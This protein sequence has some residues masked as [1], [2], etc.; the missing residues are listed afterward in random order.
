MFGHLTVATH[1]ITEDAWSGHI[2]DEDLTNAYNTDSDLP[3]AAFSILD[4]G[5][6]QRSEKGRTELAAGLAYWQSNLRGY[7]PEI[8]ELRQGPHAS[9]PRSPERP[10]MLTVQGHLIDSIRRCS[11]STMTT[12]FVFMLAALFIALFRLSGRSDLAV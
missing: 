2:L 7:D 3:A 1:H 8:R 4:Y 10:A 6:W 5:A 12:P 11:R 9:S